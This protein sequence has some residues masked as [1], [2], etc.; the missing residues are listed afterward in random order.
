MTRGGKRLWA[1]FLLLCVLASGILPV[2]ADTQEYRQQLLKAYSSAPENSSAKIET[3][4]SQLEV[5]SPAQGTMWRQIMSDWDRLNHSGFASRRGLQEGLAQDDSLCIV[6]FGY[7]LNTNGSMKQE[8]YDRLNIALQAARQYPNAY[9]AVTGGETAGVKGISEAAVMAIWLMNNDIPENRIILEKTSLSTTENAQNTCTILNQKYPQIKQLAV[10]T[11]DYHI[12]LA[13]AALQTACTYSAAMRG[14][15]EMTVVAGASCATSTSVGNNLSTQAWC[16]SA[17]TGTRW[18][19][20]STA[21][22]VQKETEPEPQEEFYAA[23]DPM[24]FEEESDT[25][26]E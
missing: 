25:W 10:V 17:I 24:A 21:S 9:I 15:R 7:G 8:L 4:L 20:S 23:D 2:K 22:A 5:E 14:G 6:V 3:L 19:S 26:Y 18:T 11:S 12:T 1:V 16:I 13:A